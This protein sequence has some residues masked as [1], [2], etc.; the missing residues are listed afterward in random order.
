MPIEI[1]ELI[2]RAT[3]TDEE[4]K[5]ESFTKM[6]ENQKEDIVETCVSQILE[7]LNKKRE[8]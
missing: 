4:T 1:R 3:I 6:D 2:I 8:R 7:I 5:K